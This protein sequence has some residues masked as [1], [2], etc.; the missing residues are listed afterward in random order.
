MKALVTGGGGFIG[1]HLARRLADDGHQVSLCDNLF[2]GRMDDDLKQLLTLPNVTFQE[3]DLTD[4]TQLI[5]LPTDQD[6]V[7]HLAAVNGTRY[8][9]EMPYEVIKT[10]LLSLINVLDW[11]EEAGCR[12]LVW[13]SSSEAYAGGVTTGLVGVPTSEESPLIITDVSNPR[14]T[15]AGSK[16]AGELL[17]WHYAMSRGVRATIVRTFNVYGPRMGYEHVIPE[18]ITRILNRESPFRVYGSDQSRAFCYVSDFITGLA[19]VAERTDEGQVRTINLGNDQEVVIRNLA[20]RLFEISDYHP[21][22]ENLPSPEGSVNRR[23]PDLTLAKELLGYRPQVPLEQ[24]LR[25]TYEWYKAHH[26]PLPLDNEYI[27]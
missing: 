21:T 3:L 6:M 7:F 4:Q 2:R 19:L 1:Y 15:Y 25:K 20:E 11:M 24:G 10:N 12:K 23:C 16:I 17:C 18:F 9:Y 13:T 22:L 5:H 27:E 8:F 26:T 14:F